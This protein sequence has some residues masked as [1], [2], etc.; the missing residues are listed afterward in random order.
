MVASRE[1]SGSVT[2]DSR[3]HMNPL[4]HTWTNRAT[5]IRCLRPMKYFLPFFAALALLGQGCGPPSSAPT[6]APSPTP[7]P[8][9]E[10]PAGA[11][12]SAPVA[13]D[14][15][16]PSVDCDAIL[17]VADVAATCGKTV[18]RRM[19]TPI[20][21]V[22]N[23]IC[24]SVIRFETTSG[25]MMQFSGLDMNNPAD[26]EFLAKQSGDAGAVPG[27]PGLYR[28]DSSSEFSGREIGIALHKGRFEA[29]L[30]NSDEQIGSGKRVGHLCDAEQLARLGAL[31]RDRLPE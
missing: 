10:R 26:A 20:A 7:E 30:T 24:P 14:T 2:H 6:P 3:I 12:P 9:E 25:Q 28:I 8:A 1:L 31:V 4:F 23:S 5:T 16:A 15:P 21:P 27:Q 22:R 18:T 13:T 17:T 29:E 19:V 11:A